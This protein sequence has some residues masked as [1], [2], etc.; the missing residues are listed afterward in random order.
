MMV[1]SKS[2][3]QDSRG[4]INFPPVCQHRGTDV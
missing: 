1:G 2:G 4:T 3:S